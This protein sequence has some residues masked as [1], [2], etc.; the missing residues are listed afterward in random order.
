MSRVREAAFAGRFYPHSR[1]GCDALLGAWTLPE[2][3][4]SIGC[5]APHAGWVYS[6]PTAL[7]SIAAIAASK[8]ECVVLFGAVHVFD[9]NRASLF[10]RGAWETPYG[11]L[12]VDERLADAVARCPDVRVDPAIH[13]HEHSIEV[14]LPLIH[15]LMGDV[16]ILPIMVRPGPH[17]A[18]VGEFTAKAA[19]DL[20]R[21]VAFLA[22]TDLTH[23][24]PAFGFEPHGRGPEGIAW[25]KDVN[26]RRFIALIDSLDADGV[27]P[28]AEVHRN[29]C[30]AGAVAATIAAVRQIGPVS[31]RELEHTTSAEVE[32]MAGRG[33]FNSVG[34]ESGAF[35]P[36]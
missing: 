35:V 13:A 19:L 7:K 9:R 2:T 20:G 31:Y 6:G 10:D 33:D 11:Q 23:Y 21:R 26:D 12:R 4:A 27:V 16:L 34:Y 29:A 5:V 3:P 14:E 18:G 1:A 17:A 36:M 32:A 25:A 28:E 24:G 30:G 22:S 8:P 15:K